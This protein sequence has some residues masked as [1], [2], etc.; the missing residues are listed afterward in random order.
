MS[1]QVFVYGTLRQGQSNAFLLAQSQFLGRYITEKHFHLFDLGEYPAAIKG[2]E[3]LVGEVYR[4]DDATLAR[5]DLLEDYPREY[6]R[7]LIDTPYGPAWIYLYQ[8]PRSL[9]RRI[10]TG[11]WCQT[12]N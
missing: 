10:L 11:D 9:K 3:L 1:A 6:D 12:Q 2:D 5:L 4:V 8:D 7:Q